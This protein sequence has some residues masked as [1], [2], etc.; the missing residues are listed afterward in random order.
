MAEPL[1]VLPVIQWLFVRCVTDP[2]SDWLDDNV[3]KVRAA[4][5]GSGSLVAVYRALH[6]H[7]INSTLVAKQGDFFFIYNTEHSHSTRISTSGVLHLRSGLS[8]FKVRGFRFKI[9]GGS[10]SSSG[11]HAVLCLGRFIY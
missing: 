2:A 1:F 6:M 8:G 7:W 9:H 3:V 5:T 11:N 10:S 4:I